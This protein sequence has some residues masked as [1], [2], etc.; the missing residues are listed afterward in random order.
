M[1]LL[2]ITIKN[3]RSITNASK[4]NLG[5]LSVLLGPN[6]EGKSN[7]LRA[8]VLAMK[9]VLGRLRELRRVGSAPAEDI[10]DWERDFPVALQESKPDGVSEFVLEF[11]L[12][13]EDEEGFL[14]EVGS[15]VKTPLPIEVTIGA[16]GVPKVVVRKRGPGSAKVTEKRTQIASFL[17]RRLD[18]D[19]IPAVRTADVV[20]GVIRSLLLRAF[21]S[22]DRD[23]KYDA[24]VKKVREIQQ[25]IFDALS[26]SV[27]DTLAQ[28]LPSVSKVTVSLGPETRRYDYLRRVEL[29]VDDGNET[30][31]RYKGD[32][33]QSLAALALLRFAAERERGDKDVV[34]AIEE[35]ESHLHPRAIHELHEVLM[36]L[37][38]VQQVVLTT[39]SQLFVDRQ[40]VSRNI[41]VQKGKAVPAKSIQEVRK[42]LGVRPADN[43]LH[44]DVVLIVEGED[45]RIALGSILSDRSSALAKALSSNRLSIDTLGGASNLSYKAGLLRSALCDYLCFMD[46]D[47]EGRKAVRL[48]QDEGLVRPADVNFAKLPHLVESEFEDLLDEQ[49]WEA[50]L[51]K[52]FGLNAFVP[53]KGDQ[54]K[55]WS[56]RVYSMF[57]TAGKTWDDSTEAAI[58]LTLAKAVAASPKQA[59][60][61]STAGPIDNLVL[62]LE[63]ALGQA[64]AKQT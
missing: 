54:K 27:R 56:D 28:F 12:S 32:G 55:K 40:V 35:P 11:S 43:L 41:I 47:Q 21:V 16:Q 63:R 1:K 34:L 36:R 53:R 29:L 22:L 39:H 46:D 37:A 62:S 42:V 18:F 9:V 24:A 7:V 8:L 20:D 61:K 5:S 6:N 2:S 51:Q 44:A 57:Q 3:F 4:L 26:S 17:S 14:L 23:P 30:E 31:L 15:K 59:V 60:R 48:A 64:L 19:Y 45:D 33:V 50:V 13:K 58:K 52:D 25:P 10:Y 49:F 38:S